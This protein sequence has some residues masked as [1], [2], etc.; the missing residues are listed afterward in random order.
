[1]DPY[2]P[3]EKYLHFI[4]AGRNQVFGFHV[5]PHTFEAKFLPED[6]N[7]KV[8]HALVANTEMGSKCYVGD[9]LDGVL[10]V[11]R[12]FSEISLEKVQSEFNHH[13][14]STMD[15]V[16]LDQV[17]YLVSG[18]ALGNIS[19]L[20]SNSRISNK[21]VAAFNIGDSIS[22]IKA[23][24]GNKQNLVLKM[25]VI[26]TSSGGLYLLS[27]LNNLSGIKEEDL[28]R[29]QNNMQTVAY[30]DSVP[31][32]DWKYISE[33]ID[34]RRS[35]LHSMLLDARLIN[36]YLEWTEDTDRPIYKKAHLN[37]TPSVK[38]NDICGFLEL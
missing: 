1:M 36:N 16:R 18:D 28:K 12:G 24:P 34:N 4:C 33:H 31:T 38:T 29:C 9:I 21:V 27:S 23:I 17:E 5:D 6:A 35:G 7:L 30:A 37:T 26:G 25:I 11:K 19:I 22:V 32:L 2:T 15:S 14:L 20:M 3:E 13:Y 8:P 10:E